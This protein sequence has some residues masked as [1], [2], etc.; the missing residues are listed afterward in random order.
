[1]CVHMLGGEE[2]ENVIVKAAE[3]QRDNWNKIWIMVR[4]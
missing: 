4:K 2:G 1:M 3:S